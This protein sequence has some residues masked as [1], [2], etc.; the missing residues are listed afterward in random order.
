MKYNQKT[1]R[2][3]AELYRR[4]KRAEAAFRYKN[5]QQPING[6]WS[7]YGVRPRSGAIWSPEELEAIVE[8]ITS[9]VNEYGRH[10]S[11]VELC[12]LAWWHG[13]SA[14]AVRDKL[15]AHLGYKKYYESFEG[16]L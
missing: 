11:E 4:I 3:H 15:I 9:L 7:G 1:L 5:P 14:N 6:A 13:R 8:N 12:F 2:E 16:T 10:L